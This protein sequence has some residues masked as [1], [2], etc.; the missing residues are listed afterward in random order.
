MLGILVVTAT[1]DPADPYTAVEA[2]QTQTSYCALPGTSPLL[3][4]RVKTHGTVGGPSCVLHHIF[5]V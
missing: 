3:L 4:E 5:V 1:T 2:Q